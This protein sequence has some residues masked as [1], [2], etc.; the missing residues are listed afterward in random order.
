MYK[1]SPGS[2]AAG[3][4]LKSILIFCLLAGLAGA[5][6]FF[7]KRRQT[8]PGG[9]ER[10]MSVIETLRI[11]GRHQ[12]SL[13][14]VQGR[15]LVV[16]SQEKGL[17]LLAELPIAAPQPETMRYIPAAPPEPIA[18]PA[19]EPMPRPIPGVVEDGRLVKDESDAFFNHLMDRI[20][21]AGNHAAPP[22]PQ[23]DSPYMPL[24]RRLQRYQ[25]G[26]NGS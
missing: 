10:A 18:P 25:L 11:A 14:Q 2:K 1:D 24:K 19:S 15:I 4:N 5:A 13:V 17:S 20:A 22:A 6:M 16:G 9:R 23:P 7:A 26:P 12:I 8:G 3:L 21:T